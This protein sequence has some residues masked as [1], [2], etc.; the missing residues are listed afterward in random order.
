MN[1]G[2]CIFVVATALCRRAALPPS[3]IEKHVDRATWLQGVSASRYL[4]ETDHTE[5]VPPF[6]VL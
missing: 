1:R 3:H 6:A 2:R 4:I 5:V